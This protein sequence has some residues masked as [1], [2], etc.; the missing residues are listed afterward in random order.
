MKKCPYCYEAIQDEAIRCRH[1]G[2]DFAAALA[3]ARAAEAAQKAEARDKRDAKVIGWIVGLIGAAIFCVVAFFAVGLLGLKYGVVSL[4]FALAFPWIG[5]R[6][7]AF[8]AAVRHDMKPDMIISSSM[9]DLYAQE[10]KLEVGPP[11]FMA[12]VAFVGTA[13][14]LVAILYGIHRID[15]GSVQ[16][17][18][19]E[20][21]VATITGAATRHGASIASPV[22]TASST[23]EGADAATA[24]RVQSTVE[25]AD[26]Q[27]AGASTPA[28]ADTGGANT[29]SGVEIAGNSP[30][31]TPGVQASFD[32]GKAVSKIEKLICSTPETA[33]ADRRLNAAYSAAH[34]KTNDPVGLK[35]DQRQW[36]KERNACDDA[37]CLLNVTLVRIQRLSAM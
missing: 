20:S 30:S 2:A 28:S 4:V 22:A 16:H 32:C 36:L 21:A 1:C 8:G 11:L 18:D 10:M 31:A 29:A 37:A 13:C 15:V 5:M 9:T 27:R 23:G 17:A 12:A 7:F 19:A 34:A 35:D 14:L 24:T 33:D 3:N 25:T 26:N 6:A